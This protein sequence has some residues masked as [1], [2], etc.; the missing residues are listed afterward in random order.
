MAEFSFSPGLRCIH[1][2]FDVT[3]INLTLVIAGARIYM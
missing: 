1:I 3:F 2:T